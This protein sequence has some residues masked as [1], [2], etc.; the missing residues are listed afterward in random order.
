L[1]KRLEELNWKTLKTEE[2]VRV[3]DSN[4]TRDEGNGETKLSA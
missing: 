4:V 2:V 3:P 1:L